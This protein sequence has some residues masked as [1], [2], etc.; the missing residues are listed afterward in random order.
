MSFECFPIKFWRKFN[1]KLV[2]VNDRGTLA[3]NLWCLCKDS[4]NPSILE[5]SDQHISFSMMLMVK[6]LAC[7]VFMLQLA[8]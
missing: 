5:I 1:L 7:L 8:I 2:A 6:C 3:P 4:W